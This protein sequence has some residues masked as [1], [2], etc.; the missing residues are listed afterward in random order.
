M[1]QQKYNSCWIL[2][3]L[4]TYL[5]TIPFYLSKI[6]LLL[7]THLCLGLPSGLFPSGF[8]TNILY[9]FQEI[10]IIIIIIIITTTT[11]SSKCDTMLK[12]QIIK[13]N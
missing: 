4:L 6:Y 8:P 5:H 11:T 10:I 13:M 3:Y 1:Q 7:F 12:A 2:L 9:A